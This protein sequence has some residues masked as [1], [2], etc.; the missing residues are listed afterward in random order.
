MAIVINI[1]VTLLGN[2]WEKNEGEKDN[3][4]SKTASLLD[5]SIDSLPTHFQLSYLFNILAPSLVSQNAYEISFAYYFQFIFLSSQL[6]D[7]NQY[8]LFCIVGGLSYF[9]I[10]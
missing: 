7:K 3:I 4:G 1:K 8:A 6:Y 5:R 2:G 9:L 10:C